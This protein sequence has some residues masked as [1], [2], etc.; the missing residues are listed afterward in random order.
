MNLLQRARLQ[1]E[2]EMLPHQAQDVIRDLIG[3]VREL[4]E[5]L[6]ASRERIADMRIE[7]DDLK[8]DKA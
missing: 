5:L 8:K 6:L 1:V 4:E 7:I 2:N 3:H